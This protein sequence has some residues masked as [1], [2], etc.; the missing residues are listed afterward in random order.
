MRKGK[1]TWLPIVTV[2]LSAAW[3][4]ADPPYFMGLG[5]LPDST[6][7]HSYGIS[8]DGHVVTG[9]SYGSPYEAF[10]WTLQ[11]GMVGLGIL[12]GSTSGS[13]GAG[14]SNDGSVIAGTTGSQAFR[15]TQTGG[16]VGLGSVPSGLGSTAHGIS[17][18]GSVIVGEA[19]MIFGD[20][21]FRWTA[22]TGMVSLGKLPGGSF[23]DSRAFGVSAD[24]NVIVGYSDSTPGYQAFRWSQADGMVGLG[25]LPG[26]SFGSSALGA[27]ADGLAIV[28]SSWTS[29]GTEAFRWTAATGMIGL[30]V[31]PGGIFWGSSANAVSEDGYTVVGNSRNQVGDD[32]AFIWDPANGIRSVRSVLETT[33]HLN[34][35][36]WSLSD[37]VSIST[38]GLTITG[39]GRGPSGGTQAWVAHLPEPITAALLLPFGILR[40]PRRNYQTC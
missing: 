35:S 34:M 27:S 32:E 3:S 26:G 7:S 31:L 10:R 11:D 9:Y 21:A 40:P 15:W 36:A 6:E 33:Y 16:M 29:Q 4:K 25:D 37:A 2:F 12:P 19:H 23:T 17:G 1:V 38:D 5:F 24:G 28:G 18:D 22:N 13:S 20:Y 39:I 30:G 14:A 8:G